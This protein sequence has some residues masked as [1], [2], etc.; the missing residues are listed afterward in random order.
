MPRKPS[1]T[2]Y[3]RGN[4]PSTYFRYYD[5]LG[6]QR[7]RSAPTLTGA[8][9]LRSKLV[10][11]AQERKR[12]LRP[13]VRDEERKRLTVAALI[14]R[15]RPDFEAKKAAVANKGYAKVWKRDLGDLLASQ[16][17]PGD[18]ETW[19]RE[20][21]LSGMSNATQN[22]HTSFLRML[23]NLGIR[24]HLVDSNPLAH[25]RIKKLGENDPRE[26]VLALSEEARLLPELEPVDRAAFV[27]SLYAGLRQG[28]V[29]RLERPDIDFERKRAKLRTT[30]AGKTQWARLNSAAIEAITWV[31]S[32]HE[33]ERL[34]PS[35]TGKGPM[36][37][38]R[39][40]DRLKA[41]SEKLGFKDVLFHTAR[42]TFVTRLASGGHDIGIVKNAAR[43]STITMTDSYMHT[44]GAATQAAVDSLCERFEDRGGFFPSAPSARGHLRALG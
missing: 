42:H 10:L 38:S 44:E 15:Y 13:T 39:M 43:H 5:E 31:M 11:E 33:H 23:F 41:A 29:L 3:K 9:Q 7:E 25:G 28:E 34:F 37:G 4:S 35:E 40:T 21:R 17:V 22:R 14:E 16:V 27:I 30:K 6:R 32:Q 20:Q 18:I 8:K 24:D 1:A 26:R 19:R 12:D 36:S 2:Y